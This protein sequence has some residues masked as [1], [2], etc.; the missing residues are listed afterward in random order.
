MEEL[1]PAEQQTPG[2]GL[3]RL[4]LARRLRLL[5]LPRLH[6][7]IT[8]LRQ[9]KVQGEALSYSSFSRFCCCCCCCSS[10]FAFAFARR[11]QPQLSSR[12][13]CRLHCL[14]Q[15]HQVP[16]LPRRLGESSLS[17]RA[18]QIRISLHSF[19]QVSGAGRFF[20]LRLLL[21]VLL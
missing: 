21:L 20:L 3:F 9:G 19:G 11:L 2:P 7:M 5:V 10:D 12:R 13:H 16:C 14:H 1:P 6:L 18:E 4:F 17:H 8:R 15:V